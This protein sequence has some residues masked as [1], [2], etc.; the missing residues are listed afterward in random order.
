MHAF[1]LTLLSSIFLTGCSRSNPNYCEVPEDCD[2]V[3]ANDYCDIGGVITDTGL[4]NTCVPTPNDDT[5]NEVEQ[6]RCDADEFCQISTDPE[7]KNECVDCLVDGDCP[8]N[9]ATCSDNNKCVAAS[10]TQ[11]ND[12]SCAAIDED[13]P[14]CGLNGLCAECNSNTQ[15]TSTIDT[16][17][18]ELDDGVCRACLI[19]SECASGVCN[20]DREE[21]V[22]PALIVYVDGNGGLDMG[23]C[24]SIE[25]PCETIN[26]GLVELVNPKTTMLV[27]TGTYNQHLV[28]NDV[29]GLIVG[30]EGAVVAPIYVNGDIAVNISGDS[31][32]RF[33]NL[34][35]IPNGQGGPSSVALRCQGSLG[36]PP[37][38]EFKGGTIGPTLGRG[39]VV[40]RCDFSLLG[41]IITEN[42]RGG[43]DIEESDFRIVNNLIIDNG[44][45]GNNGS[46]K[47][48]VTLLATDN[49]DEIFDFNTVSGNGT[50]E[51]INTGGA[52][53]CN[54]TELVASSNIVFSGNQSGGGGLIVGDCQFEFSLIRDTGSD[55]PD[56]IFP[57]ASNINGDPL[58]I[59]PGTIDYRLELGSPCIN[60]GDK[61]LG[62]LT[63]I[64]GQLRPS[65]DNPNPDCGAAEFYPA[66]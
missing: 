37:T 23:G 15:C 56:E 45:N 61:D 36:N 2:G 28:I 34:D 49:R 42:K 58:F 19:N 3:G 46:L 30:E 11:G 39:V 16:P 59:N 47:G 27:R 4:T 55:S 6:G 8:L 52:I 38:L 50:R 9:G 41:S 7:D 60:A 10:C 32:I 12:A 65:P 20:V 57:G 35:I 66:P 44:N 13:A 18:C 62:V 43:V 31:D 53:D 5:C 40:S 48:G 33:E 64:D 63:D 22:R 17:V 24:G 25:N 26:G 54:G 1:Y 14:V 21:C 29:S 51:G